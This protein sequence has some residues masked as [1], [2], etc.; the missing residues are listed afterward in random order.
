MERGSNYNVKGII[1]ERERDGD[2]N[3]SGIIISFVKGII[4]MGR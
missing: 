2:Y 3:L 1:M 4:N